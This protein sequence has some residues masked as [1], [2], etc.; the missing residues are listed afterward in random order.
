MRIF[1]AMVQSHS[2]VVTALVTAGR[3]SVRTCKRVVPPAYTPT[4]IKK[5]PLE[6]RTVHRMLKCTNPGWFNSLECVHAIYIHVIG[7]L[8]DTE[9]L[10]EIGAVRHNTTAGSLVQKLAIAIHSVQT[11]FTFLPRD[12]MQCNARYCCRNLICLS[13]CQMRVLWQI[14]IIVCQYLNTIWNR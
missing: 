4:R 3:I 7:E 9:K 1:V 10:R 13:V 5:L 2:A 14:G 12:C 8:Q 11:R 6:F